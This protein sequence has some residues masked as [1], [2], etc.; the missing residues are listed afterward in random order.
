MEGDGVI[1]LWRMLMSG[2]SPFRRAGCLGKAG[3]AL[4]FLAVLVALYAGADT[5]FRGVEIG[6]EPEVTVITETVSRTPPV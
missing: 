6:P 4:A 1:R 5:F 2:T 3:L